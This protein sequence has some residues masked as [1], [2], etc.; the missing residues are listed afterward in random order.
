MLNCPDDFVLSDIRSWLLE[1]EPADRRQALVGCSLDDAVTDAEWRIVS[2]DGQVLV[3]VDDDDPTGKRKGR[4][5][6]LRLSADAVLTVPDELAETQRDLL[7]QALGPP[8]SPEEEKTREMLELMGIDPQRLGGFDWQ[9]RVAELGWAVE[10][11]EPVSRDE[12]REV[13]LRLRTVKSNR[14]AV[15]LFDKIADSDPDQLTR[16][17][18]ALY[19][20]SHSRDLGRAKVALEYTEGLAE[21]HRSLPRGLLAA[22]LVQRAACWCDLGEWSKADETARWAW[23]VEQSDFCSAVFGRIRRERGG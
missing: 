9:K 4:R 6:L 8:A 16:A 7:A 20:A 3:V 5:D 14:P 1:Q 2:V 19:A 12:L 10:Q 15:R 23:A 17:A 13:H 11:C 22:V 18:A 21:G